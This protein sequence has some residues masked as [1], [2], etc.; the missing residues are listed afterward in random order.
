M[1]SALW[2]C[3][4]TDACTLYPYTAN[5]INVIII[6]VYPF[7]LCGLLRPSAA[8]AALAPALHTCH[9]WLQQASAIRRGPPRTGST[10]SVSATLSAESLCLA[11][12][13]FAQNWAKVVELSAVFS[14]KAE[15]AEQEAGQGAEQGAEE[16]ARRTVRDDGAEGQVL[17]HVMHA[18]A[19][20]H[21]YS[22][23]QKDQKYLV[24]SL[25]VECV[26]GALKAAVAVGKQPV[27]GTAES[28]DGA[29]G[30]TGATG[31]T[32][33][34]AEASEVWLALARLHHHDRHDRS[35][36]RSCLQV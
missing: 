12:A 33:G 35:A 18:T 28:G 14:R 23:V 13:F 34:V 21:H 36:A 5:V 29:T 7:N 1:L 31:V 17:G 24:K 19:C 26:I 6:P 27:E 30:A 2:R 22:T 8:L 32:Q 25:Q 9:A 10:H 4:S 11:S 3:V 15:A 16:G 20:L